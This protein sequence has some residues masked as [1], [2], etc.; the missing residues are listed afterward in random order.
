M[1]NES[2]N[3]ISLGSIDSLPHHPNKIKHDKT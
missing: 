1:S 2:N 3:K